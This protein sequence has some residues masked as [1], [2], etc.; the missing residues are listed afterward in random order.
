MALELFPSFSLYRG[1]YEL[2][3]YAMS[4]QTLNVPGM[5]WKDVNKD[6]D[7]MRAVLIIIIVEWIIMLPTAYFLDGILAFGGDRHC[8]QFFSSVIPWN[9]TTFPRVVQ[10]NDNVH[11]N[12]EG[13]D[14]LF[15]VN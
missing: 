15:E 14:V 11:V 6:K 9:H 13:S 3:E 8:F 7:G 5:S 10:H 12:L 1:I 2:S 4:A